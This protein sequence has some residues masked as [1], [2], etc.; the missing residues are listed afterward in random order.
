MDGYKTVSNT[1]NICLQDIYKQYVA[2]ITGR[3]GTKRLRKEEK[4]EKEA[5]K[6]HSQ[7]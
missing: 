5:S 3:E 2:N 6:K 1:K 4:E 7:L